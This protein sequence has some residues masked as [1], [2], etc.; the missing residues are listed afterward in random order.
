M[1]LIQY[2]I[3]QVNNEEKYT[4]ILLL[5]RNPLEQFQAL[6]IDVGDFL[7]TISLVAA[8]PYQPVQFRH[9][10]RF[11]SN[12]TEQ[13]FYQKHDCF[14]P[15]FMAA[16]SERALKSYQKTSR[17]KNSHPFLFEYRNSRF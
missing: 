10:D 16:A 4:L 11:R 12:E 6:F 17:N 8:A 2:S 14:T 9:T 13:Q 3:S 7:R 5:R 15:H 1:N